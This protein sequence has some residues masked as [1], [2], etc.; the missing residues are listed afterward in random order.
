MV[1]VDQ[2]QPGE[3]KKLCTKQEYLKLFKKPAEYFIQ[4]GFSEEV[5]NQFDVRYYPFKRYVDNEPFFTNRCIV[6]TY[7]IVG[8]NVIGICGRSIFEEI[9]PKWQNSL[10]FPGAKILYNIWTAAQHIKLSRSVVIVEGPCDV[11]R[12]WEAKVYNSVALFGG[13]GLT[14]AKHLQLDKLGVMNIRLMLDNDKAG[15][16]QTE[17]I[18]KQYNRFYNIKNIQL[19][20]GVKDPADMSAQALG[21]L[22]K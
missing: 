15:Q 19:P 10:H 17:S 22:L 18:I 12:L 14:P 13:A 6:P 2:P 5:L 9:K 4:R 1:Q 8:Q 21:E 7:D 3:I 20:S 16:E 11:W